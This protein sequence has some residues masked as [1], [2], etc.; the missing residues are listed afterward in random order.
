[1]SAAMMQTDLCQVYLDKGADVN[2]TDEEGY[3]ALHQACDTGNIPLISLL[4]EEAADVLR[5]TATG[6]TTLALARVRWQG[7]GTLQR[8]SDLLVPAMELA[9]GTNPLLGAG[10]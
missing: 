5:C 9:G 1:M 8:I 7:T 4:F 2:A 3:T 6:Q 10:E